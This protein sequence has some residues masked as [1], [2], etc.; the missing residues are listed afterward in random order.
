MIKTAFL[1]L[2]LL[3]STTLAQ[4]VQP[5]QWKDEA[6]LVMNGRPLPTA[7]VESC[8]TPSMAKDIKSRLTSSLQNQGCSIQDWKFNTPNLVVKI[9]CKNEQG[10]GQGIMKGTVNSTSYKVA[11]NLKVNH[12][13]AGQIV[14]N[15][16]YQGKLIGNCATKASK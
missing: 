16:T 9:S 1:T 6:I 15:A 4:T 7:V 11:G 3:S 12:Q 13:T 5:G 10:T 8:V 2:L 14:F